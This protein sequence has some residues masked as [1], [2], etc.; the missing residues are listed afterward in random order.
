MSLVEKKYEVVGWNG[1]EHKKYNKKE[2]KKV[3]ANV[4]TI[5]DWFDKKIEKK[6]VGAE[7]KAQI[8]QLLKEYQ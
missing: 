2:V 6:E 8:E 7:E 5:P 1:K 4:E 3:V